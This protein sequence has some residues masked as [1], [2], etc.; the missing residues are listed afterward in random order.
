LNTIPVTIQP[1]FQTLQAQS[2]FV[3]NVSSIGA[4]SEKP[5]AGGRI[6][7]SSDHANQQNSRMEIR[8]ESQLTEAV[9]EAARKISAPPSIN[10]NDANSRIER[11]RKIKSIGCL[12]IIITIIVL[13]IVLVSRVIISGSINDMSTSAKCGMGSS[14]DYRIC[15]SG[16]MHPA[17]T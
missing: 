14:Q 4:F 12:V 6:R 13:L 16:T 5:G 17:G 7:T 8:R 15:S 9:L 10:G 11:N 3:D 2:P 1:Q